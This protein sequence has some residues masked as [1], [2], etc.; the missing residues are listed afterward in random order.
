[1]LSKIEEREREPRAGL[2]V[3]M[4]I[5]AHNMLICSLKECAISN[6]NFPLQLIV[7]EMTTDDSTPNPAFVKAFMNKLDWPAVV[8]AAAQVVILVCVTLTTTMCE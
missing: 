3:E 2:R 6:K 8:Y 4:R 5:C 1:V 7:R